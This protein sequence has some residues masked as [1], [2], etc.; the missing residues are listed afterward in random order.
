MVFDTIS[1]IDVYIGLALN[2]LF[3]GLG[4]ALGTY[5]ANK[6]VIEN[7]KKLIQKIKGKRKKPK[8]K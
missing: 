5:L 3:T 6:H 1:K 4:A 8:N 2:G 7:A